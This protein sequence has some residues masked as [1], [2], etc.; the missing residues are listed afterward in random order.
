MVTQK[1]CISWQEYYFV[2]LT[3]KSQD[4]ILSCCHSNKH[5]C[6]NF[7]I[8]LL[9]AKMVRH[10]PFISRDWLGLVWAFFWFIMPRKFLF[11]LLQ[12]NTLSL[13]RSKP[14]KDEEKAYN[15][16]LE[17]IDEFPSKP[18]RKK[19]SILI[20]H[21]TLKGISNKAIIAKVRSCLHVF[22]YYL[23]P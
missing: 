1:Y 7:C 15:K 11:Y 13:R 23:L 18:D 5:S 10:G 22:L 12:V 6:L 19:P 8:I 16:T 2:T 9:L 21:T 3:F 17:F 14:F 20:S 4:K